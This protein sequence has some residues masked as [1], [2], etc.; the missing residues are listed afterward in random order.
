MSIA[1][2][3]RIQTYM[4]CGTCMDK[5]TL[6]TDEKIAVGWTIQGLQ[7]VCENCGKNLIDLDFKGQKMHVY[8]K[9]KKTI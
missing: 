5:E 2:E 9:K 4:H 7:V 6:T 1:K 8:P 3:S